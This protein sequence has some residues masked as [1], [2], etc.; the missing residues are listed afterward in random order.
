MKK[1]LLLLFAVGY[2]GYGRAQTT[3]DYRRCLEADGK[4][5]K[6]YIFD[7]FER[8][9]VV[10]LGERD[11]RDTTQYALIL[12][13]LADPRFSERIGHVYTEV[14]T[15]NRTGSVNALIKGDYASDR[16]FRDALLAYYRNEIF[17][18]LWEKTNRIQFLTGLYRINRSLPVERRLTLG[19]TDV[20]FSWEEIGSSDAYR[21]FVTSPAFD[22]RDSTM[23]ANFLSLYERQQ[24]INGRRKALLITSQPHAASRGTKVKSEGVYLR[25]HLGERVRIVLL[26]EYDMIRQDRLVDEG[27]WDA[28][29]EMTGCRPVG[30]DLA[31]TP[32]GRTVYSRGNTWE[33][34]ADGLIYHTPVY[35]HVAA[36]GIEGILTPDFEEELMRRIGIY[37]GAFAPGREFTRE[38]AREEYAVFHCEPSV[39]FFASPEEIKRQILDHVRQSTDN[40]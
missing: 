39:A 1:L 5:I 34:V 7:L 6:E 25:L 8:T 9:D 12:D 4:D 30:L 31:G 29:F 40:Q 35:D 13:L 37:I 16:Q 28:A 14:G 10:V 18:P 21:D 24:P 26:N 36:W 38:M 3:D 23:A 15:I 20:A 19:L 11:H 17:Y 32:F 33:E 22:N 27:R 2:A